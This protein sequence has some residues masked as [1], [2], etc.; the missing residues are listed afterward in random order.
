MTASVGLLTVY[1]RIGAKWRRALAFGVILAALF[2]AMSTKE[3]GVV[4]MPISLGWFLIS[5][6][7]KRRTREPVDL[8]CRFAYVVASVIAGI[9]FF[10]LRSHFVS[11]SLAGG[12]YTQYYRLEWTSLII[13]TSRWLAW[14][15]RDFPF[16]LP[17]AVF[18][19]VALFQKRLAQR[20]L[21][22]DSG[23]WMAGWIVV[24]LPWH[25]VLEY[26]LLPFALG[27]AV[28]C[29]SALIQMV[30]I[31]DSSSSKPLRV[32]AS[33]CF[34]LCL[35]F[36]CVALANNV[37]NF[38]LQLA[39]D[40]ANADAV[41]FI[42]G[43]PPNSRVAVNLPESSEYFY[44]LG[45][46]L[47]DIRK[48]PDI[49]LKAFAGPNSALPNIKVPWYILTPVLENQLLPSIRIALDENSV[50]A[51]NRSLAPALGNEA[52]L[53]YRAVRHVQLLDFGLHRICCLFSHQASVGIW[54]NYPRPFI[55]TRV[56]RYGW[57]VYRISQANH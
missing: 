11:P 56:C 17:I 57:K 1:G 45:L 2:L 12:G 29:G 35:V 52:Q 49:S 19:A 21:L 48:R 50:G 16:L 42:A 51:W 28:F 22:V 26:Y 46:H 25:S 27:C 39:V 33:V 43:L 6:W 54:C 36:V 14:L 41:D 8:Q 13:S 10:A 38:R 53:T 37:T 47:S 32:L 55:E 23:I 30:R 3:T 40:D 7:W 24:C 20:L 5:L 18:V 31:Q 4:I 15:T 44:E 9:G 34:K